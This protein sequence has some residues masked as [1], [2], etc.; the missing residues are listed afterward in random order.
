MDEESLGAWCFPSSTRQTWQLEQSDGRVT[1]YKFWSRLIAYIL[2]PGWG[3]RTLTQS[4]T[5]IL[6]GSGCDWHLHDHSSE[7]VSVHFPHRNS[8]NSENSDDEV[9]DSNHLLSHFSCV[10][11]CATLWTVAH[12]TPLPMVFSRW[13]YSSGL[14]CPPPVDLPYPGIEPTSLMPPVL[15]GRSFTTST[16]WEAQ[17]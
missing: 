7:W 6:T 4:S 15:A 14:P 13:E 9:D 5:S 1:V 12:Q 16:P 3:V 8:K 11:L 2:I 17:H 10:W